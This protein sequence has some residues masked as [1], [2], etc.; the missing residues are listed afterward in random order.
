MDYS[1]VIDLIVNKDAFTNFKNL[2]EIIDRYCNM[3]LC[4]IY[5]LHMPVQFSGHIYCPEHKFMIQLSVLSSKYDIN[6]QLVP[7]LSI[8]MF[9][10]TAIICT[11]INNMIKNE[12][13]KVNA[14]FSV[15]ECCVEPIIMINDEDGIIIVKIG[16]VIKC[17]GIIIKF[18][19]SIDHID[20][21]EHTD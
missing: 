15:L 17:Y 16:E 4:D 7:L 3:I 8:G 20:C 21:I 6:T 18:D 11:L 5:D 2:P 13:P 9:Y 1:K 12:L 19:S 14:G 10:D